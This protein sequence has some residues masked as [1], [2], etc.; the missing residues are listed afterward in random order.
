MQSHLL[1]DGDFHP[2]RGGVP[3]RHLTSE[4]R[5]GHR[6]P[7]PCLRFSWALAP[8]TQVPKSPVQSMQ[9]N[10]QI[11]NPVSPAQATQKTQVSLGAGR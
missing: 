1:Y 11:A 4:E 9:L 7:G 8:D 6:G 3:G 2:P 10:K 5:P